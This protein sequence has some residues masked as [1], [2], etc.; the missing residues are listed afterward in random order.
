ML[1]AV[2]VA[3]TLVALMV[4]VLLV[5]VMVGQVIQRLLRH[6][7]PPTQAPAVVAQ[8]DLKLF[9]R[10]VMAAQELSSSD[11]LIL[12]PQPP[13]LQVRP[14]LLHL[15]DTEF[16]LLLVAEQLHSNHGTFCKT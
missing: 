12:F 16:I 6:L 8:V 5:A 15:V 7:Q 2:V 11:T 9:C 3:Q 4:Q 10:A 13:Q 1:A 14:L